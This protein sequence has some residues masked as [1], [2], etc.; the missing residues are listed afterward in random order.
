MDKWFNS[1]KGV[2]G[3]VSNHTLHPEH[4]RESSTF[5]GAAASAA[6]ADTGGAF[7]AHATVAAAVASTRDAL[8]PGAM[9]DVQNEAAARKTREDSARAS[10]VLKPT[11]A[12]NPK[13]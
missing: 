5:D 9:V 6:T 1:V 7:D 8:T 11:E 13:P 12:V 3:L 2:V 10:A 4:D